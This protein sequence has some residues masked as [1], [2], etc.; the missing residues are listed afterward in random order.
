M[1]K[2]YI[3]TLAVI[4]TLLVAT[5]FVGTGYGVWLSEKTPIENNIRNVD[6]FKIFS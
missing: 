6:C 4:L 5:L 3:I 1:Q 2:K